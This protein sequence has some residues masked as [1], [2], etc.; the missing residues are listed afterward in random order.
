MRWPCLLSC[1]VA[2]GLFA[3]GARGDE[4]TE[5]PVRFGLTSTAPSNA[6]LVACG[7]DDALRRAVEERLRRPVFGEDADY[8]FTLEL[9]EGGARARIVGRDRAG[10]ELGRR[11]VPMPVGDC[12]KTIDTLAVVLAIMIGAPRTIVVPVAPSAPPPATS[13]PQPAPRRERWSAGPTAGFV[14]GAGILPGASWGIEGGALVRTSVPWASFLVRGAYWPRR[15]TG[16]RRLAVVDR[17]SFAALGCAEV[18]RPG[19][20]AVDLCA[21]ADVGRLHANTSSLTRA[22]QSTLLLDAILEGR[23][24]YRFERRGVTVEPALAVQIAALLQR[25]RFTYRDVDGRQLILL[26]PAPVAFQASFGAGVHFW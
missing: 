18:L 12:A 2:L 21:G 14:V 6:P 23:V 5:R 26:Q 17:L 15:P 9:E 16:E 1:A 3:R 7:G 22:S 13:A 8:T 10:A 20:F 11:D 4:P 25:D 24:A 19:P